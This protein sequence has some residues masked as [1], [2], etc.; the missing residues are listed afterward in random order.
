M[1]YFVRI[2]ELFRLKLTLTRFVCLLLFVSRFPIRA[3]DR[4][5]FSE[6]DICVRLIQQLGPD[7]MC[8]I[9]L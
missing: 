2:S 5:K 1:K 7:V 4:T 6:V 3:G 9:E 8:V